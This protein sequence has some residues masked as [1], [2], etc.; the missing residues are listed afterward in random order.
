MKI[1]L[2]ASVV[3]AFAIALTLAGCGA[4]SEGKVH[5]KSYSEGY[6]YTTNICAA[7]DKN[8]FCT[9]NIPQQNYSPPSWSLDL[10]NGDKHGWKGVTEQEYNS[11]KV[12]DWYGTEGDENNF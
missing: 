3:G 4:P 5:D 6:Y 1:K 9:V 7:Y 2:I 10:Y 8:G 12:G 11:V